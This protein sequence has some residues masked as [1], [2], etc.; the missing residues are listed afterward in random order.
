[1]TGHIDRLI[2]TSRIGKDAAMETITVSDAKTHLL[3]LVKRA[4]L[5]GE[6]FLLSLHGEPAA[7][8][9]PANPETTD[10]AAVVDRMLARRKREHVTLGKGLNIRGLIDDGRK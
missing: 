4:K 7:Q 6:S 9:L 2:D 8:L 1:M 5:G 3:K 10:A